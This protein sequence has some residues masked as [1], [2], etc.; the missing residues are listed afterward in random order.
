MSDAEYG[1]PGNSSFPFFVGGEMLN[2]LF[3]YNF[4]IFFH[5]NTMI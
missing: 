4:F 1:P 3:L 2:L 5:V